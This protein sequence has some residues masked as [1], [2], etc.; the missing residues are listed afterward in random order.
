MDKCFAFT[1]QAN[2]PSHNLNFTEGEGDGIESFYL[3]K[4]FLLY[5]D[6]QVISCQVYG[7]GVVLVADLRVLVYLGGGRIPSMDISP[8]SKEFCRYGRLR[9]KKGT[10]HGCGFRFNS[11]WNLVVNVSGSSTPLIKP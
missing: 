9:F 11:C 7:P 3:S 10:R 6:R 5:E 4:S 2:F 8:D 1:P